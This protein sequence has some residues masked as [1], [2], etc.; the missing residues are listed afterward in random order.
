M[1]LALA[2]Q[3]ASSVA[4]PLQRARRS[5]QSEAWRRLPPKAAPTRPFRLPAAREARLAN[6]ATL[7]LIEDRR[8]P[9]VTIEVGIPAGGVNDPARQPGLAEATAELIKE[10]AGS[11]TSEQLAREVETLGGRLFSASGDDYTEVGGAVVSENAERMVEIIGD[12]VLRPTFPA[13]EVALYKNNRIQNLAVQRQDPAF[14]L[15]EHFNRI[16]YGAHPYATSAPTPD[17][18]ASMDRAKI[19]EFYKANYT[20]AG[21]VIVIVGDFDPAKME[22]RARAV[23]DRWK[24][25][26]TREATFPA[27]VDRAALRVYLID[28][29]GSEQ[30][31]FR[32]GNLATARSGAGY[33]P[34]LVTNTILGGGTSSRLFLNI[35]EQKGYSYDVYS[36]VNAPLQRGTFYG[37]A[38]TRTEV[39]LA[40]I[41]EMLAE[42]DR[43]RRLKVTAA[44]LRNAKNYLNG[45]FSLVL[46]TQGGVADQIVQAHMLRL[47]KDYL[48]NYRAQVEAV[49]AVDVQEAARRFI[50]IDRPAIVVV[51]DAAKLKRGLSTLG[52]VE[53]F[54]ID[55]KLKPA[56]SLR[57]SA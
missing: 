55:G 45:V 5:P 18:V 34:L 38:Q 22:A 13:D 50:L 52:P 48:A 30:A 3:G 57:K 23:F 21:A 10:G 35:R 56:E 53:V 26:A 29:P 42:F 43:M 37:T 14:L 28:R 46:S 2:A 31:D 4:Q 27:I 39:T 25:P 33:F 49:T 15:S 19:E 51:G 54:D 32:I 6:G 17:S 40:A 44:D 16:I 8:T 12:V 24:A 20:P 9:M 7:M 1:I 36:A 11:R 41:K 47:G